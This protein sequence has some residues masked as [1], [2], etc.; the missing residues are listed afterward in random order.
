MVTRTHYLQ[1]LET[2]KNK[3]FIKVITG[4]RRC[5]KSTLMSEFQ[6]VLTN[7]ETLQNFH[8]DIDDITRP[9]KN[10]SWRVRKVA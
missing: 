1:Q 9:L 10:L 5:G 4:V 2:V 6:Q 8:I 3:H 7:S